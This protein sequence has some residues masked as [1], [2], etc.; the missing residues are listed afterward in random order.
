MDALP[1]CCCP[2]DT[3]NTCGQGLVLLQPSVVACLPGMQCLLLHMLLTASWQP[4]SATHHMHQWL[5]LRWWAV[6]VGGKNEPLLPPVLA[7]DTFHGSLR[8][9]E[10]KREGCSCMRMG[11]LPGLPDATACMRLFCC[12]LKSVSRVQPQGVLQ[13]TRVQ[14]GQSSLGQVS[15]MLCVCVCVLCDLA[16]PLVLAP[17]PCQPARPV[18]CTALLLPPLILVRVQGVRWQQQS[19]LTSLPGV[20]SCLHALLHTCTLT[21]ALDSSRAPF[22][23]VIRSASAC[24]GCSVRQCS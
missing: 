14:P 2:C 20:S 5:G 7:T 12:T 3:N 10:R 17:V 6:T 24:D 8:K 21:F 23:A 22:P 1:L 11:S 13:C 19:A 16:L 18:P 9:R 15:R 4:T